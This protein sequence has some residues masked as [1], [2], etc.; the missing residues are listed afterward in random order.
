MYHNVFVCDKTI[1]TAE[2]LVAGKGVASDSDNNREHKLVEEQ[3]EAQPLKYCRQHQSTEKYGRT[4][5]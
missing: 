3:E 5:I 4:R 1:H 2:A